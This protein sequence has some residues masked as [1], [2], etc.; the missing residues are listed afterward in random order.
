[1]KPT[2]WAIERGKD[3]LYVGPASDIHKGKLS[4]I[5]FSIILNPTLSPAQR[6]QHIADAEFIVSKINTP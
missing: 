3:I 1:M 6:E 5:A 2:L 4:R